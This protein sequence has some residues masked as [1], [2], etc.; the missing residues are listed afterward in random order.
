MPDPGSGR[1][2]AANQKEPVAAKRILLGTHESYAMLLQPV[3]D[4]FQAFFEFLVFGNGLK[5]APG[6]T[7]AFPV[8]D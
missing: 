4:S 8:G 7:A 2:V 1:E 5:K 3:L 6:G